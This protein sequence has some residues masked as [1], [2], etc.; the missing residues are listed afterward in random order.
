MNKYAVVGKNINYS[1]SPLIHNHHFKC[2][3][4]NATYELFNI[5][6]LDNS[7]AKLRKLSGF[8]VT[9]PYKIDIFEKCDEISE[10]VKE[11][12]AVNC[13]KVV[14][15][16]FY[17]FNTD[18]YGFFQLL[19]KNKLI[20]GNLKVLIIGSGGAAK[21]V[22]YC[23]NNFTNHSIFVTNRT[24]EK[25]KQLTT[26]TILINEVVLE[27]FDIIINCT[28]VGVKNYQSPIEINKI[29][30]ESVFIDI[31]Y[32]AKSKFLIDAYNL[33][34]KTIN[35]EDMLIYQAAKS[36]EIWFDKE[37]NITYLEESI[38]KG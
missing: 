21:A 28:N 19:K 8:N 36:F 1:L 17:G 12:K 26:N 14:N 16:K 2:L 18:V 11:I 30:K 34:A 10:E 29:K 7:M 38:R 4:L 32:Q 13:V 3:N 27:Q 9:V 25:A 37:A 20:E 31:N 35:G 23:L 15:G 24:I 5:D 33:N 6:T 22:N